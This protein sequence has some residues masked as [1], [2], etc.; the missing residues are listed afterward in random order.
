MQLYVLMVIM[1]VHLH[2]NVDKDACC[3]CAMH[4]YLIYEYNKLPNSGSYHCSIAHLG[5]SVYSSC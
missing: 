5:P 4:V 1:I 2:L 3:H